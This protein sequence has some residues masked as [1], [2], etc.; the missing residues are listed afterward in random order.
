MIVY[1]FLRKK[2]LNMKKLTGIV[3]A[4]IFTAGMAGAETID[5]I[6]AKINDEIIT[7]SELRREMEPYRREIMSKVPAAQQEQALKE[8]EERIL[9]SLIEAALIYQK[10]IE[11]EYEAEVEDDVT[12]YIQEIMK[13]NNI[14]DTEE[15]ENALA[16]DGQSLKSF[17]ESI[18]KS[19]I[20][21][22][23]V[24]AFIN[25]RISLLTPEIERYYQNNQANFTT[26]EEVTLSEIILDTAKGIPDAESRAS[27]IADRM[28]QGESFEKLAG[29]YSKGTTAAKGGGIGT[30]V[31]DKLN[32]EIRKALVN[33][34]EGEISAPQ[35]SADGLIIYRV[36]NRKP[37]VVQPLDDV[38]DEIRNT[39]YMQKRNPEY[40]RFITQLKED[41]YIQ[42]F[43]EMQ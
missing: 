18:E 26:P 17:R 35:K 11:M 14:R 15:F 4:V 3:L 16:Q 9:N 24:N 10:A 29:Q 27:E 30:Y 5:R 22:A 38:K 19:M 20:S 2:E 8:T 41:A 33:V 32:A 43:P 28:R 40:E 37:A 39:L 7:L 25:S 1:R 13:D 21:Q 36:D 23:L 42:I 12:E 6:L 31:V 34:E